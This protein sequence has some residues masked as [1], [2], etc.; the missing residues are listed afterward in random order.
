MSE[1]DHKKRR[2]FYEDKF[3]EGPCDPSEDYFTDEM[4]KR[5][6]TDLESRVGDR[7]SVSWEKL[8]KSDIGFYGPVA[9]ENFFVLK[10]IVDYYKNM[11]INCYF[12]MLEGSSVHP[13]CETYKELRDA[14]KTEQHPHTSRWRMEWMFSYKKA[15]VVKS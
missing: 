6:L 13:N 4:C 15:A 14:N 8:Y 9:S 12:S 11:D 10:D 2:L 5:L 1:P 3:D 7:K